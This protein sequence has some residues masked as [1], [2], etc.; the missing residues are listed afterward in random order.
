MHLRYPSRV[1]FDMLYGN[2]RNPNLVYSKEILI[3]A[4]P[5]RYLV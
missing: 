4:L 1:C 3:Y 2:P 5:Q